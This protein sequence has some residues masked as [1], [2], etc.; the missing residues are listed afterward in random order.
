MHTHTH[1]PHTHTQTQT[2][3]DSLTHTHTQTLS[4]THTQTHTHTHTQHTHSDTHTHTHTHTLRHTHTHTHT[5]RHPHT[6]THYSDSTTR[7]TDRHTH[8][9]HPTPH[10]THTTSQTR[11]HDSLSH[12]TTHARTAYT[13]LSV[14]PMSISVCLCAQ[15]MAGAS[16]FLRQSSVQAAKQAAGGGWSQAGGRLELRSQNAAVPEIEDE[17]QRERE[18]SVRERHQLRQERDALS[19]WDAS[20]S[21]SITPSHV[22]SDQTCLSLCQREGCG[23]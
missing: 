19:R 8:T 6:H 15:E 11:A 23:R 20:H 9:A 3:V 17:A 21:L 16:A 10:H 2:H 13:L 12:T 4:H 5:L 22:T 14:Y 7:H 18:S 1:T